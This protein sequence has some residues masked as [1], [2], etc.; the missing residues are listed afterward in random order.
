MVPENTISAS[1][2]DTLFSD[3]VNFT[4]FIIWAHAI[5][6]TDSMSATKVY[7]SLFIFKERSFSI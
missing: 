1:V 3:V 7:L 2:S 5:V 6:A 4:G